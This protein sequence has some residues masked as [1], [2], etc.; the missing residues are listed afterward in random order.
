MPVKGISD[1]IILS[2]N[3]KVDVPKLAIVKTKDTSVIPT[4][5]EE[6]IPKENIEKRDANEEQK[7][8][9]KKK[10]HRHRH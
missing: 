7:V 4:I 1:N 3:N 9:K 6:V 10:K 5:G 8:T 2:Q